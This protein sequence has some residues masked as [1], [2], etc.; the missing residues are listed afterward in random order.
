MKVVFIEPEHEGNIG[1]IARLMKNFELSEFWLVA[2]KVNIGDEARALASHAQDII[3]SL[4]IVDN[5]DKALSEVS[6]VVGTTSILPKRSSNIRRTSITPQELAYIVCAI[7]GKVALLLGRE[8]TGLSNEELAKCD[9]IVTIPSNPMYR[10]LNVALASAIIFYE[11]WKVK[12]TN[13]RGYVEEA[14][15]EYR[16]R[17]QM[18]FSQICQKANLPTHKERLVKEA[19]RNVT[20]R[21]FISKRE[22]TLLIGAFRE[23]FQ[24]GLEM[25]RASTG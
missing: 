14:D 13:R 1:S 2:P 7:K 19:F 24:R 10:T 23:F 9:I 15:R 21:A 17:L 5:L 16:E 6:Y 8:S 4:V 22:A 25:S 18:L 12:L 3:A 20:S 11:L